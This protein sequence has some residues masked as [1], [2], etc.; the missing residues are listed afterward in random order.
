MPPNWQ[1]AARSP[2]DEARARSQLRKAGERKGATRWESGRWGRLAKAWPGS[3]QNGVASCAGR[4]GSGPGRAGGL[5][6]DLPFAIGI[7]AGFGVGIGDIGGRFCCCQR[8]FRFA[9]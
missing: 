1:R 3:E 5:G 6:M 4:E 8:G 7:W 2:E 9:T